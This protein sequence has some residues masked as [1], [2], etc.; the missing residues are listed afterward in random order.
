MSTQ[1]LEVRI[2]AGPS[3]P[4]EPLQGW[5]PCVVPHSHHAHVPKGHTTVS[6][7]A[8]SVL[9]GSILSKVVSGFVA[10]R[11]AIKTKRTVFNYVLAVVTCKVRVRF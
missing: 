1:R 3:S 11:H 2:D 8:Y 6:P 5:F 10:P 9:G 7:E 4:V